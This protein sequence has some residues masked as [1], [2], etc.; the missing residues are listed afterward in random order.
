VSAR[1]PLRMTKSIEE[2]IHRLYRWVV[3]Q[4]RHHPTPWMNNP[5]SDYNCSDNL[6][7]AWTTSVRSVFIAVTY[8][9]ALVR[10]EKDVS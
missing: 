6:D 1:H 5:I 3:L 4:I 9:Y 8:N 7:Q 10:Q 2:S